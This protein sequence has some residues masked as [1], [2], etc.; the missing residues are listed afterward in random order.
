MYIY[1]FTYI[2]IKRER[3]IWLMEGNR[4]SIGR[5]QSGQSG[6]TICRGSRAAGSI[7]QS[8]DW[9]NRAIGQSDPIGNRAQ[10]A[11]RANRESGQSGQS[12]QSGIHLNRADR[13][14]QFDRE[15]GTRAA[16]GPTSVLFQKGSGH[17]KYKQGRKI[18]NSF[19]HISIYSYSSLDLAP[20]KH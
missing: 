16:P 1:T 3:Y 14:M 20:R 6:K 5:V 11:N 7:G 13:E 12:G 10:G 18:D 15:W 4:E 17:D 19:M 8:G 2:Y 9:V